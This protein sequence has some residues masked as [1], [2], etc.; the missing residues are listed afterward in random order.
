MAH[1]RHGV[2]LP[3]KV[4]ALALAGLVGLNFFVVFL[5]TLSLMGSRQQYYVR[6]ETVSRN[7]AALL[8]QTISGE[9]A[10]MDLALQGIVDEAERGGGESRS[11]GPR[12]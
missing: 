6:A 2:G 10:R 12:G 3:P 7:V 11:D 1:E 4:V 9:I 8:A 5:A